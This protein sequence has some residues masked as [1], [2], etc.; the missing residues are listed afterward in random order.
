[1]LFERKIYHKLKEWKELSHGQTALLL[2]GA[3]RIGKS[4]I[5]ETF[6]QNEYEDY[7]ILDFAQESKE[8][9]KNFEDNIGD[10]DTF[11]RNLFLLKGK[12]LSNGNCVIIFDEVQ[13]FPTARQAIKYLVK[14][15]R[16]DYMETGSLI[17]IKK[18]VQHILIPSEEYRLKMY[19]MDFE[20]FLWAKKDNVTMS[21]IRDAFTRKKPLGDPIH[22]KI[23]QIFRTYIA[24]GGMP[25]AVQAFVDGK[26][27]QEIDFIK[28]SILS[29]YDNDLRKYDNDTHEKAS[30]IFKTIPEQLGNHNSHFKFS[31][32][33]KNARYKNYVEA[34]NFIAESMV[35][36][37][38]IN[39]TSPEV[40]LEAYADRSNFKLY[41]GDTGLLIT[42]IMKTQDT[43]ED[44][45]YKA[46]IFGKLGINQGMILENMVA[47]MLKAN[48]YDLFF[49][50]FMYRD[51]EAAKEKKYEIDFLFVKKKK[52]CPIEVKSSSYKNHKS[53]D[54]FLQKYQLKTEDKFILYAKDFKYEDG[55]MYLPLYM[56]ICL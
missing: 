15:G 20:E 28:R 39:V 29:L 54:L 24:V 17:S 6:A 46:L 10:L 23:M 3:R 5:V 55:I 2:E 13:L 8:I 32:V 50:E 34:V 16:F 42:Q 26:S 49:H 7:L 56:T 12:T 4:T 21:V 22:R 51:K 33:D 44:N 37:E 38:C 11:F 27:Y 31:L 45:L 14:D 1:M 40:S 43:T 41:M 19:P 48:G 52:I 9:K 47:Q 30:V 35:G 25:Q 18:N 36:N 53:F